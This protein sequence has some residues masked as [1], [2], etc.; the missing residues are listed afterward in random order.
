MMGVG[1]GATALS[2]APASADGRRGY[3][4]SAPSTHFHYQPE[5]RQ[6]SK[7]ATHSD[8]GSGEEDADD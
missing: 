6:D 2:L 1:V 7:G 8:P 3:G 4:V 5:Y